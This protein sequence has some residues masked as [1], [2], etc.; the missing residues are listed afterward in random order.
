[1]DGL[2]AQGANL[3][4]FGGERAYKTIKTRFC[5]FWRCHSGRIRL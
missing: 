3:G 5:R 4:E 1:M 2:E